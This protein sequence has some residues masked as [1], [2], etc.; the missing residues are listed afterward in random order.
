MAR[1]LAP[2]LPAAGEASA[3]TYRLL[4]TLVD[5]ARAGALEH[6]AGP[7]AGVAK[8]LE[9]IQAALHAEPPDAERLAELDVPALARIADLSRAHF[10]RRFSRAVGMAPGEY[11]MQERMRRAAE[12]LARRDASVKAV[13]LSLGFYDPNYFAK[14]FRRAFGLSPREFR[15]SGMYLDIRRHGDGG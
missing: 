4:A 5:G 3:L 11:L 6:A 13:A 7:P 1:L 12:L 9:H 10:S 15:S 2:P 8:A 14:A